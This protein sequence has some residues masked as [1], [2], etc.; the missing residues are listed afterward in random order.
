MHD[1]IRRAECRVT[2]IDIEQ[3]ELD[4]D[5]VG[6]ADVA[7]A[8]QDFDAVWASLPPRDQVR[9]V[10]LLVDRVAYDGRAGRIAITFRPNGIRTL[11]AELARREE[12]AA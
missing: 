5:I 1:G 11:A 10:E 7:A 4:G 9:V 2:E 8:L 12:D 3:A 6:E